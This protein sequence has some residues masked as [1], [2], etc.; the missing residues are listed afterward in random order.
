V[1]PVFTIS[2]LTSNSQLQLSTLLEVIMINELVAEEK[3]KLYE[4]EQQLIQLENGNS[5]ISPDYITLGLKEVSAKFE[6]IE[7]L[8]NKERQKRDDYKRKLDIVKKTH[9]HVS[10]SLNNFYIRHPHL[11]KKSSLFA[12]KVGNIHSQSTYDND[13]ALEMAENGSLERS[14]RM[15]NDYLSIGQDTLSELVGQRERLKG[16]QRKAFDIMNYLGLSNT[17]MKNVELRD[18]VD[19]WLVYIGMIAILGLIFL[20]Y[21]FWKK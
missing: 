5:S 21:F 19:K 2:P 8:I 18:W 11:A 9:S 16:I 1:L 13:M 7:K 14:S 15:I 3:Q 20:I 17:I 6:E 4:L 12:G 10:D